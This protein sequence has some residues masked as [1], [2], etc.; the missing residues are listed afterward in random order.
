VKFGGIRLSLGHLQGNKGSLCG[1]TVDKVVMLFRSQHYVIT[2]S[3]FVT[4]FP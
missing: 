3:F 4:I 2:A 1:R